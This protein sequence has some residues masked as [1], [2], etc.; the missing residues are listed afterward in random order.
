VKAAPLVELSALSDEILLPPVGEVMVTLA[1]RW[2]ELNAIN[3]RAR[4]SRNAVIFR[5][6]L[7]ALFPVQTEIGEACTFHLQRNDCI[8]L[9]TRTSG[10]STD[11]P[12]W[13]KGNRVRGIP[14]LQGLG[15]K[16]GRR[17]QP[18][19]ESRPTVCRTRVALLAMRTTSLAPVRCRQTLRVLAL[20][21]ALQRGS[22]GPPRSAWR[23]VR[24]DVQLSAAARRDFAQ[25]DRGG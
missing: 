2:T 1:H 24:I 16:G 17:G 12:P 22:I 23:M 9:T 13:E 15:S 19:T 18:H 14:R 7:K 6:W 21:S 25:N 8:G 5:N 4:P 3:P 20:Q 11:L 10:Q